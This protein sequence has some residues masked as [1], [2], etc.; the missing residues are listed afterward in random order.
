VVAVAAKYSDAILAG[1]EGHKEVATFY[2]NR[3]TCHFKLG[4]YSAVIADC[5]SALKIDPD[6]LKC[7]VRRAQVVMSSL[8]S[9]LHWTKKAVTLSPHGSVSEQAYELD[10]KI[11]E[12]HDDYQRILKLDATNRCLLTIPCSARLQRWC[13]AQSHLL[14]PSVHAAGSQPRFAAARTAGTSA[15]DAVLTRPPLAPLT[16][17]S[18]WR[19]RGGWR[20]RLR[21]SGSASRRR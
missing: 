16:A 9:I 11:C 5:T 12:A 13:R 15:G 8:P 20:S 19:R 10:K 3:A 4:D 2:N 21:R 6:H 1:P 18:P 7:L 14:R 17:A